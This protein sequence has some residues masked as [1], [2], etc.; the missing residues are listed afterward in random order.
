MTHPDTTI[1]ICTSDRGTLIDMT[2][3]STFVCIYPEFKL[4]IVDKISNI[5]TKQTTAPFRSD[6]RLRYIHSYTYRLST[7][8]NTELIVSNTDV[9]II[10]DDGCAVPPRGAGPGP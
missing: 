6:P 3:R 5:R 4:V 9:V 7:V 10:T 8:L 1:L 2:I